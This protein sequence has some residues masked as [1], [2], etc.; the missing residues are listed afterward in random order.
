VKLDLNLT[1]WQE[2]QFAGQTVMLAAMADEDRGSGIRCRAQSGQRQ[3]H[4]VPGSIGATV[5]QTSNDIAPD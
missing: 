3:L 4:Q 1:H 2:C 5:A